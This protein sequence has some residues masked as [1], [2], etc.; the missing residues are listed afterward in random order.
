HFML[1]AAARAGKQVKGMSSAVADALMAY[2]WPGNVRE[3]QNSI[4]RAVILTAH[5]T[6]MLDDL[7]EK[8]RRAES[9]KIDAEDPSEFPPT[10]E[11]ERRYILR[12]LDA[13]GG[14][15]TMAAK[16]LGFDRRTIT[17]K[18]KTYG[19]TGNDTE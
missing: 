3:L 6:L 9:T 17:R 16:I 8:V 11:V 12:V 5:D 10:S 14:N 4:E 18:L 2:R 7:P 13:V 1:D 15:R 19:I